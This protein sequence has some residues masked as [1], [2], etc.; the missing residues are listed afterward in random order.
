M[1]KKKTK[2]KQFKEFIN[3]TKTLSVIFILLLGLVVFLTI[4]CINKNKEADNNKFANMVIPVYELNTNYEFS[5]NAKILAET[6]EYVF[7]IVNYRKDKLNKEEVSYQIEINN[8]TD[9]IIKVYKDDNKKD[10]MDDQKQTII[11][12]KNLSIKEKEN[13]YYHVK[14]TKFNKLKNTDK[15]SVKI[16][17]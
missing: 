9:S 13:I 4:L 8:E 17:N 12:G 7:K 10:L 15:I 3:S 5:I 1:K 14:V 2:K 11:K 6:D 16:T